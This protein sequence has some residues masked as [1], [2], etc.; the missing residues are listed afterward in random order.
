MT[1]ISTG[2]VSS[3]SRF[4]LCFALFSLACPISIAQVVM[5][6]SPQGTFRSNVRQLPVSGPY[7]IS[8]TVVDSVSGE[9]IRRAQVSLHG[10]AQQ[11]AVLSDASG[12]FSFENLPSGMYVL[13]AARPGYFNKRSAALTLR[14]GD[15]ALG[16]Q[17]PGSVKLILVPASTIEGNI[18]NAQGEP[19]EGIA[20]SALR[21]RVQNG[22][23]IWAHAG[24]AQSDEDGHYRM[25]RLEP[26]TYILQTSSR[27]E[28]PMVPMKDSEQKGY[29]GVYFPTAPDQ[30]SATRIRLDPGQQMRADFE[31]ALEPVYR[32]SGIAPVG[33]MAVSIQATDSAG[34]SVGTVGFSAGNSDN[35]GFEIQNLPAGSYELHVDAYPPAAPGQNHLTA[36]MPITV[37]PS[38]TGLVFALHPS[39]SIPIEAHV[40]GSGPPID[41][42]I[43]MN[44]MS[45]VRLVSQS[46]GQVISPSF[47]APNDKPEAVLHEV[48]PGKYSAELEWFAPCQ[49]SG[50][51]VS[52][53]VYASSLRIGSVDLMHEP[54]VVPDAGLADPIEL[55]LKDDGAAIS[56]SLD[57]AEP[58]GAVS[59]VVV[60]EGSNAQPSVRPF[61]AAAGESSVCGFAPGEYTIAAIKNNG[62]EIEYKNPEV[63]RSLLTNAVHVSLSPSRVT[64]VRLN[65]VESVGDGQ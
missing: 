65:L 5:G 12:H 46:G 61:Y 57:K 7:A 38:R 49:I 43:E 41:N 23:R 6:T 60:P 10:G 55:V 45:S 42:M 31:L 64:S 59:L 33:E 19:L 27:L 48:P 4:A 47:A 44:A 22:S 1:R 13:A 35:G 50:K 9:A 21:S 26:G 54:L 37:G 51:Q 36:T 14:L 56:V 17:S 53:G 29:R 40:E 8:G 16:E 25:A 15:Q 3:S 32:V 58:N 62:E 39:T 52:R 63:L 24:S 28:H 2:C 20:V 11:N 34:N 18:K 30:A